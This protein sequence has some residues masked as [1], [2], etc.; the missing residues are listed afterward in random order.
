MPEKERKILRFLFE[1]EL[2]LK[3][4]AEKM[5]ISREKVRQLKEK[6]LRRLRSIQNR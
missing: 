4:I 1:E 5:E 6:A 3:E 2:T